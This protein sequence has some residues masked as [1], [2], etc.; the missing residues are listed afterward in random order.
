MLRIG[1]I[2]YANCTPI[3]HVLREHFPCSEYEF[4]CG[5]PTELNR[6]LKLGEI[7][8]CPSS[9]IEYALYHDKYRIL[10]HLSISSDGPVA[11]VLLFSRIP[12]EDLDGKSILLSSE[13]ATSVNLL[14]ILMAQRYNCC[15]RYAVTT[16]PFQDALVDSSAL[17]LI[18]DAALRAALTDSGLLVYDLGALWR[19][20]TCLP[21][22]FALWLCRRDI[23]DSPDMVELTSRLIKARILLP[24]YYPEIAEKALET[25]WMGHDRLLKYWRDN[26]LYDLDNRKISGLNTFFK[27]CSEL[28]LIESLPDLDFTDTKTSCLTG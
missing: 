17:L 13:S 1:Q 19:D 27:K 25:I 21:F 22:V 26:I 14:K 2:E 18:G 8:V 12:I 15:C 28:K 5:V 10:P 20:W 7:D 23:A 3:Y 16:L 24:M 11:S 6:L 4:V 9:S